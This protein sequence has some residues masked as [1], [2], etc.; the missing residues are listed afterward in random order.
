MHE[1]A[2]TRAGAARRLL[3]VA[4]ALVVAV[5]GALAAL[6]AACA[7][8][9]HAEEAAQLAVGSPN[10]YGGFGTTWMWADGEVAYCANPSA[11]T[12]S[13][14]TYSKSSIDAPSGRSAETVANLWFSYGSPGFDASLWPDT[15]YDGSAMS[16]AHYAALAHILVSDTYTSDGSYALYGCNAAF[17]SWCKREVIGFGDSGQ[18]INENAT[19]RKICQRM[20]EVPGNFH[21][22]QLY[23]GSSTQLILSFSYVPYGAIE[24]DK[25]SSNA[26]LSDSNPCYSLA[27]AEYT[28][29]SDSACTSPAGTIVTDGGGHGS[30]GELVPGT[31]YVKETKAAK[32]FALDGG[33]YEARVEPG[34]TTALNGGGVSDVPKSDP[35]A[36]LVMK[37]DAT[38]GESVPEGA[39]TLEGAEFT[40]SFYGGLH[41][42]AE[43]AEASGEPLRTW[44]FRTDSDGFADYADEYKVSGPELFRMGNGDATMPLG[45]AVIQE[46]KAPEGYNLDDGAG[47]E[48]K[49]FCVRITDDGAQGEAVYTYNSPTVPD[50]VKRGDYRLVKEVPTELSE[51]SQETERVLLEGVEFQLINSSA[52]AVVS[53]ETGELVEPGD[54]VCTITTDENGLASTRNARANGWGLPEGWSGALAYGTYTVHEVIPGD[55]AADFKARYGYD[56]IAVPDWKATISEEGQYDNPVLVNNHIPQ[57]P[58]RIVKVDSETG[59]QIPLQCSFKLFDSAGEPVTWTS[60]YPDTQVLDT[61]TT[62]ASGEVTLPMLLEQGEYT[63]T[64]VQAPE[65][66]VRSLE[67]KPFTVGAVYNGWDDPITV[68]FANAPQ[69]GTITVAKTDSATGEAVGDSVYVV[70]AAAD[71]VTG[72]G[73]ARAKAGEIVATLTTGTDGKA[74]TPEL[75]LGTYTVYEAKV[76]D[77]YALDVEEKTV[78][79]AYQGQEVAL[80]DEALPVEDE[81]TELTLLK[82]DAGDGH[83]LEG[84]EFRIW[85]DEGTFD[86]TLATDAEGR[87]ALGY[88]KH[89]S[90][91]VQETKAPE[92]YADVDGTVRDVTVNDQGM[93]QAEDGT[94]TSQLEISVENVKKEMRTTA[95]DSSS[96]THEGQARESLSIVDKVE[97]SGCVP[98]KAYTVTG[99]L[100]DRAT[101]EPA[102]DDHGAEITAEAQF[103]AES[104]SGTVELTFTFDGAEAAGK[105]L[106]AFE[107]MTTEGRE[108][109]VH[110]DLSDEGQTVRILDIG[111]QAT[112]PATGTHEASAEDDLE[113]VD[114]V[115]YEGLTPGSS[116]KLFTT[117]VDKESGEP[118]KGEDGQPAVAETRFVAETSEGSVE[119]PVT[120]DASELAGKSLVFFEKL[121]DSDDAVIATH[122]DASDEGQTI[123]FTGNPPSSEKPGG[124]LPQTGD[125]APLVAAAI[126]AAGGFSVLATVGL[127]KLILKRLGKRADAESGI[128]PDAEE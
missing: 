121:S 41:E 111:T 91:H 42:T 49:K 26:S 125:S 24:L 94:M 36:M 18:V 38:T 81:P 79:L 107:T 12:P 85:N 117:L 43:D 44:V 120:V 87:I 127:R 54:V 61:W 106:V 73:T 104:P 1:N 58:L 11:S 4:L 78:T 9:A 83:A 20:D 99:K 51:D 64:E 101:G 22:F 74:T 124:R 116:Y 6:S 88:L 30:L 48:P 28:V 45:T 109:M 114:K 29:Y 33:V 27:G 25:S 59:R 66:Y 62:N 63:I 16:D 123:S 70:K 31:Y 108:Y 32:D 56:L 39:A 97:H 105:Q 122:E 68:E 37:A 102:F 5:S 76:K 96:G 67:G 34:Q 118:I 90:Y 112:N 110:A 46:T 95:T 100:M 86:E 103:T 60:R 69:K 47:G 128:G 71:I 115:S 77:G 119:V 55:V 126:A 17:K 65:G 82:V 113:L 93:F 8:Q 10:Y 21:A 35:V 2:T 53:P 40:V 13:A 3:N 52:N 80:F 50:A 72:D 19:G 84:A 57:T 7:Q 89:G 14:G 75:Y 98:G 92:G 15:W 23:T